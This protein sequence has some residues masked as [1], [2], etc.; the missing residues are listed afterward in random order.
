MVAIIFQACPYI[1]EEQGNYCKLY[2]GAH[3]ITTALK[4]INSTVRIYGKK[5]ILTLLLL[6]L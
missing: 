2:Q 3:N 1:L 5:V 6:T 4:K